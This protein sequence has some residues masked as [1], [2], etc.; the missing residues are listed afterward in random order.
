MVVVDHPKVVEML[1]KSCQDANV[2]C[3]CLVDVN[4]GQNRTGVDPSE[5]LN[6]AKLVHAQPNLVL[7]GVQMYVGN[8]QH[9][10]L[11]ISLKRLIFSF[12]FLDSIF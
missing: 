10:I 11:Q 5:A 6:L 8:L 4:G 9:V 12:I 3:M 7:K 2:K 1:Q